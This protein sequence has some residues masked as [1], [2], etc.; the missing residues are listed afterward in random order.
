MVD[1]YTNSENNGHATGLPIRCPRKTITS[2][3][4]QFNA[5]R[6][7]LSKRARGDEKER[8]H[9]L[10][11]IEYIE[12]EGRLL[13]LAIAV[14]MALSCWYCKQDQDGERNRKP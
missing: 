1:G 14:A 4:G 8:F 9:T 6:W 11:A 2:E 13:E 10:L 7:A 3:V 12:F 5:T